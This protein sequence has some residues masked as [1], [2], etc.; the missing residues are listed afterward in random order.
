[1]TTS[2]SFVPS[3]RPLGHALFTKHQ[4]LAPSRCGAHRPLCS[5]SHL[6]SHK[7]RHGDSNVTAQRPSIALEKRSK[8]YFF[9]LLSAARNRDKR[10]LASAMKAL[11]EDKEYLNQLQS[12]DAGLAD[13]LHVQDVLLKAASRCG[14]VDL[15]DRLLTVRNG[16]GCKISCL[17]LKDQMQPD[18]LMKGTAVKSGFCTHQHC[19]FNL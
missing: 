14:Q 9:K 7:P 13:P 8:Q 17:M 15:A 16:M 11:G 3:W 10:L 1:M 6:L 18:F 4:Q 12:A 5:R 2:Y 19:P